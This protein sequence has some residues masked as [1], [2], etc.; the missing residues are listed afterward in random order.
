MLRLELGAHER[1]I[2]LGRGSPELGRGGRQRLPGAAR[3]AWQGCVSVQG[4]APEDGARAVWAGHPDADLTTYYQDNCAD[5]QNIGVDGRCLSELN[6][7]RVCCPRSK[8]AL[9][10]SAL[11]KL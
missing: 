10:E 5:D 3:E 4:E 11:R 9:G 2:Q 7:I 1:L 8:P 6:G